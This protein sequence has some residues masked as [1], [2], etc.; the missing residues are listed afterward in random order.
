MRVPIVTRRREAARKS[1]ESATM[2]KTLAA[3]DAS[4]LETGAV[5]KG[6]LNGNAATMMSAAGR[7]PGTGVSGPREPGTSW[8]NQGGTSSKLIA[9]VTQNLS[10][11]FGRAPED[12]EMALAEQ[13]MS[14]G[15]PFPP[16][17][18]LD[19][20]FGYRR[21]ARTFD[22]PVG[23]NVQ[24]T[25]RSNRVPFPTIKSIYEAYDVAQIC[26]R[27]LINDV[28][29]LDFNWEPIP[30]VQDDVSED[31]EKAIEFFDSPDKRQPFRAWLAEYLQDV[32]RYDAGA[33][34]IRRNEAGEPIAWEVVDGTTIIPLVDFY[35]RRPEEEEDETATPD[36][37]YGAGAVPA[38]VQIIEGMPWDWLTSD[39][40]IYQPWNPLP[41]SQ[42]GLAPLEAVLLSANT[43]IRFQWHFLQFFTEGTLPAGFM[44]A[45]PDQSDPA[46]IA[47]WQETWDAIMQGDQSKTR[48][49]RWVPNGAK[50]EST[51]PEADKFSA[52]FVLYLARRTMASFGVT[53]NDLGFTED[54][55]RATGD[56]Q[57]DVQFRVG[58]SP[59]LRHCEDVINLFTKQHLKLR[60]RIRFDDGRETED[61]VATATADGIYVDKGVKGVDEVRVG[62]GLPIDKTRPIPRFVNNAKAGPIPLLAIESTGGIIDPETY[63]PGEGQEV[64]DVPYAPVSELRVEEEKEDAAEDLTETPEGE[65]EVPD[66]EEGVDSIEKIL[67]DLNALLKDVSINTTTVTGGTDGITVPTGIQGEDLDDE[68]EEDDTLKKAELALSVRRWRDNSRNR[69]KKG[70]APRRFV[71]PNMPPE[72]HDAIWSKLQ[73]AKNRQEVDRAFK[74]TR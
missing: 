7:T 49:V 47:S 9:R 73:H 30:G 27:H 36:D 19:P 72:V 16:G 35:G 53:P 54:V 22:Y 62:L 2:A 13:G 60:C 45:P 71:D 14:W 25:P 51:K 56:T 44:Q 38:Y 58:T 37:L 17:R 57:V 64:L 43:D 29:S 69:L 23:T 10:Q 65:V 18:P 21:P 48:Q 55:N 28:R 5:E 12:L 11:A 26:V 61:R 33:L 32:L 74:G 6:F 52:D 8:S 31:I 15:P 42:Y 41:D 46:Q 67:S 68:D 66:E 4:L 40:L 3:V 50:F 70:R 24:L 39:D 1:I 34:Y 59:L 20:F 63:A